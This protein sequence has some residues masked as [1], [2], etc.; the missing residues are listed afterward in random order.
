MRS[1]SRT[2]VPVEGFLYE[3]DLEEEE[4]EED[5]EDEGLKGSNFSE[6]YAWHFDMLHDEARLKAFCEAFDRLPRSVLQHVAVDIGCGT[7]ILGLS[8]LKQRPELPKVVAFESDPV[9]AE[10]A[11]ANAVEN[12][13]AS[14][15]KVHAV[16]S[17]AVCFDRPDRAKLLVAEILDA[18]LLGEDC[19]RTLRHASES[20]L[21]EDYWAVPASADVFACAVESSMLTTFQTAETAWWTRR[22]PKTVRED[23]GDANPHDVALEKLLATGKAHLLSDEFHALSF[24]F[25]SLPSSHRAKLLEVTVRRSGRLD[26]IVFWWY[27]YML[28]GDQV[29]SMTNAPSSFSQSTKRE[30]DHWR[31]AVC[32][33]PHPRPLVQAGQVLRLAV[34]HTDED[35]WFRIQDH[36]PT[37]PV[38]LPQASSNLALLSS[39]RLWML[40]DQEKYQELQRSLHWAVKSLYKASSRWANIQVVDLS[41][42]PFMSLLACNSLR[43]YGWT[44]KGRRLRRMLRMAPTSSLISLESSEEDLQVAKELFTARRPGVQGRLFVPKVRH[45]LGSPCLAPKSVSMIC[46]EPF[47]R[48]CEGLP[49]DCQLWHHWAQVDALRFSL[50]P[51]GVLLPRSFRLKAVLLSCQDLWRRRQELSSVVGVDVSAVNRLH[52]ERRNG[53]EGTIL[54][55]GRPRFPCGLWQVE[56]AILSDPVTLCQVDLAEDF[57]ESFQRFPGVTLRSKCPGVHAIA[58]WT[59]V[60]FSKATDWIPTVRIEKDTAR[61]QPSPMMQG[62]LLAKKMVK[63]TAV[64]V[65]SCFSAADGT[66]YLQ[67]RWSNGAAF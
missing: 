60:C 16:R 38:E 45:L 7:G 62:I 6:R 18:G 37:G 41:D 17:T 59:E 44:P 35:I 33:L 55:P 67:A 11:Q 51:E 8:L 28:R 24:D 57:P 29:P 27:C 12:N 4:V 50:K 13:L 26:A 61:F 65:E 19:L 10:V 53:S 2:P 20:L 14:K 22:A 49:C 66:L 47:A 32:V 21:T 9:L 3:E 64:W 42:G 15:L 58:T 31:Q 34:F 52:P 5:E 23:Q 30:I 39:S 40:S 36:L 46:G 25:E 56:H 48:E 43:R 54:V 1:R 63:D